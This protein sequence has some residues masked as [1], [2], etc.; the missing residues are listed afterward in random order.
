MIIKRPSLA[1]LALC[2][3]FTTVAV[4]A[5][6]QSASNAETLQKLDRLTERVRVT[7]GDAAKIVPL[8]VT[9][10]R[11]PDA[12]VRERA[13]D[14]LTLIAR[15]DPV[16]GSIAF[17]ALATMMDD[18]DPQV[19][20]EILRGLTLISDMHDTL[21]PQALTILGMM[22]AAPAT[23]PY[24]RANAF[25]ML[26]SLPGGDSVLVAQARDIITPF[27]ADPDPAL[28]ARAAQS[29]WAA[30]S[31]LPLAGRAPAAAA[32]QPLKNDPDADVRADADRYIRLILCDKPNFNDCL[33]P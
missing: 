14:V 3:L 25:I 11:T 7:P 32:L 1:A 17:S 22:I 27:L 18:P 20:Y 5:W 21:K 24:I 29:M 28:R 6:P 23:T 10:A 31:G 33:R 12:E 26:T 16:A 2:A 15:R 19:Q 30:H 4:P 9:L 13:V 8:I